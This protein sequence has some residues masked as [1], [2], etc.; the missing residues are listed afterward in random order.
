M[1]IT[2]DLKIQWNR[3]TF[4]PCTSAFIRKKALET[5]FPDSDSISTS[6]S[7]CFGVL[8]L[9]TWEINHR[10][11]N[12][13]SSKISQ[14][15][16]S[17]YGLL[18]SG[19]QFYFNCP[20]L[21]GHPSFPTILK[22]N[23]DWIENL[24]RIKMLN[25][26]R[27]YYSRNMSTKRLSQTAAHAA[28]KPEWHKTAFRS[29]IIQ[30]WSCTENVLKP[31]PV[32]AE[33]KPLCFLKHPETQPRQRAGETNT[34]SEDFLRLPT[35]SHVGVVDLFEDHPGFIVLPHLT[36]GKVRARE[37]KINSCDQHQSRLL[38]DGNRLPSAIIYTAHKYTPL[39]S[40][41]RAKIM[42][43]TTTVTHFTSKG[44]YPAAEKLL[45]L[46]FR[47]LFWVLDDSHFLVWWNICWGNTLNLTVVLL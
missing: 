44:N 12:D 43:V 28:N 45:A 23:D 2:A 24:I 7:S 30:M 22:A 13:Y 3:K 46:I 40:L 16:D 34:H 20:Y 25:L 5:G 17:N 18:Y 26:N 10:K 32:V 42:R 4:T 31:V 41:T 47:L 38:R 8:I 35:R 36:G 11:H 15:Y 33:Y 9:F 14:W 6:S 29:I 21:C 27:W 1:S 39:I 37:D 19:S